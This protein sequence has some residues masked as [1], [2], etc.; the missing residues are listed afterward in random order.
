MQ[1]DIIFPLKYVFF[2]YHVLSVPKHLLPG[3]LAQVDHMQTT[4]LFHNVVIKIISPSKWGYRNR[5][6]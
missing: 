6:N 2:F 4:R 1:T 3:H 5:G